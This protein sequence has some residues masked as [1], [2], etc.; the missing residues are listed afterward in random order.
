LNVFTVAPT[1]GGPEP[2]DTRIALPVRLGCTTLPTITITAASGQGLRSYNWTLDMEKLPTSPVDSPFSLPAVQ[3]FLV[4]Y[5]RKA[6]LSDLYAAGTV[7]LSN[8]TK[9]PL[10]LSEATWMAVGSQAEEA[11]SGALD[12]PKSPDGLIVIPGGSGSN[13]LDCKFAANLGGSH[14]HNI[15]VGGITLEGKP[16]LSGPHSSV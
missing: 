13:A 6:T 8:P 3:D 15:I 7:T 16:G 10:K 12:C 14:M 2:I 1:K 11:I 5:R 4:T 9:K